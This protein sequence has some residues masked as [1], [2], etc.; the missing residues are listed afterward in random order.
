MVDSH[1][2]LNSHSA[3]SQRKKMEIFYKLLIC[4]EYVKA[5]ALLHRLLKK[6]PAIIIVLFQQIV[7]HKIAENKKQFSH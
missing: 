1:F 7:H 3:Y 6:L 4:A 5:L 2:D